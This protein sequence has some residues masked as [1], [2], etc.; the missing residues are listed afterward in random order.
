LCPE[1]FTV[2]DTSVADNVQVPGNEVACREA[3]GACPVQ[4]IQ[5]E[6]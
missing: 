1:V 5:I 4:V 6:E 3:A 2:T